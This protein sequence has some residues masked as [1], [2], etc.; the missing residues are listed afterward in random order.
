MVDMVV[1]RRELA[2]TLARLLRFLGATPPDAGASDPPSSSDRA[3]ADSPL[4]LPL[5]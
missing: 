1:D 3:A 5:A 2:P 4:D